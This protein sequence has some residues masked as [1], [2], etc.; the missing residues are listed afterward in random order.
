M[1]DGSGE[2]VSLADDVEFVRDPLPGY[3]IG[4]GGNPELLCGRPDPAGPDEW[5]NLGSIRVECTPQEA[6]VL[7]LE[8]SGEAGA[9]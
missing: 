6:A 5:G 4:Y 8:A 3:Y 2:S 9:V 7:L 1:L